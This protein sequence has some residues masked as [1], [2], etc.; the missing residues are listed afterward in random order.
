MSL[1]N[2]GR[3]VIKKHPKWLGIASR[4]YSFIF[5]NHIKIKGKNNTFD[6]KNIFMKKCKLTIVGDNNYIKIGNMS[7]LQNTNITIFGNNNKIVLGEKVFVLNGDF[8]LEDSNNDLKIGDKTTFSGNTHLAL[9]EG[10]KI[11]IGENCLFSSNIVFRT[12]DSHSILN[13]QGER[14][15]YGE[16]ISVENHVWFTLNVTVLKGTKILK[17]SIIATGSIVTKEFEESNVILGGNPA[18]II[19]RDINWQ[20]ERI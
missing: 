1:Y 16:D 15:N 13:L 6:R 19:K 5:Y 14:I 7:Y 3:K 12:G 9:T 8:Y 20:H 2:W 4:I 17:D 11:V 10:R 18:K